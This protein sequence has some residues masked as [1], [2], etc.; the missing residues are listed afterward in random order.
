MTQFAPATRVSMDGSL[1]LSGAGD[2]IA[3]ATALLEGLQIKLKV[4]TIHLVTV[5]VAKVERTKVFFSV[6]TE[7]V[8]NLNV[9]NDIWASLH[10]TNDVAAPCIHRVAPFVPAPE[11]IEAP[12]PLTRAKRP[13]RKSNT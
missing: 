5:V 13:A 1:I 2:L 9:G 11:V 12:E 8:A 6:V 7:N 10:K 3:R 4:Q